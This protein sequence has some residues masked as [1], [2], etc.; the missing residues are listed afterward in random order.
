M[1][2]VPYSPG[3]YQ[4]VKRG[5]EYHGCEYI[6]KNIIKYIYVCLYITKRINTGEGWA[7]NT[8]PKQYN[9][10]SWATYSGTPGL[11]GKR[12]YTLNHTHIFTQ[13][14][15]IHMQTSWNRY[16]SSGWSRSKPV[17]ESAWMRNDSWASS[18]CSLRASVQITRHLATSTENE[19]DGS[20]L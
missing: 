19:F 17:H 10:K 4:V 8:N 11:R 20:P 18:A 5:W 6:Y 1:Y 7:Q 13:S 16:P 9:L 12:R 15:A 14:C 2:K 3:G